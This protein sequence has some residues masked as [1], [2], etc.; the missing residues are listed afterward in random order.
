MDQENKNPKQEKRTQQFVIFEVLEYDPVVKRF[1]KHENKPIEVPLNVEG[2][3]RSYTAMKIFYHSWYRSGPSAKNP[4]IVASDIFSYGSGC[5]QLWEFINT[6][7]G[8]RLPLSKIEALSF[9]EIKNRLKGLNC[10]LTLETKGKST[11]IVSVAPV[12]SG[13]KLIIPKEGLEV[14]EYLLSGRERVDPKS[15]FDDLL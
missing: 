11:K 12:T 5:C 2:N 8:K 13:G 10:M 14:P 7:I 4:Y 15:A 9:E 1:K 6:A 3:N